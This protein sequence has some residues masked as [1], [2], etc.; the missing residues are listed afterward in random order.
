MRRDGVSDADKI[1][2]PAGSHEH[3]FW[4]FTG[5]GVYW[6][7]FQ[8]SG[9]RVG[10]S[11]PVASLETT[12]VFEVLPLPPPTN[13]PTWQVMQWPPWTTNS[14]TAPLAD[15]DGD[16]IPNLYEYALNL[17]PTNR[18]PATAAPLFSFVTNNAQKYGSLTFTR[19][20][21]A[22]DLDYAPEATSGLPGGWSPMTNVVSVTPNP[23]G[24]TEVVTVRDFLSA[25]N[26]QRFFRLRVGL[27]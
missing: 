24:L 3:Y 23:N 5:A 16:K 8:S 11:I 9:T 17:S 27:K 2:L 19:Y 25:T 15:P 6:L 20:K 12:F 14:I 4:G 18:D 22:L 7:S 1:T 13:F 21:P 10:E 26:R